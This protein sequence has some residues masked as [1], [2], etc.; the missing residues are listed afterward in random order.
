[1]SHRDAC[2]LRFPDTLTGIVTAGE[3][4]TELWEIRFMSAWLMEYAEHR[5]WQSTVIPRVLIEQMD[6]YD[7]G[8]NDGVSELKTLK[9]GS[10]E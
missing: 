8:L 4:L 9:S 5:A 2:S 6:L 10:S 3:T 7:I 1:M